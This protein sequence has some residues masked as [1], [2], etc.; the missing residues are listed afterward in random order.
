[1]ILLSNDKAVREEI[2][3]LLSDIKAMRERLGFHW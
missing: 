1:M 3:L 2:S